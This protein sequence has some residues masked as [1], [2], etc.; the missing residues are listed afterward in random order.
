[1]GLVENAKINGKSYER[2]TE[3]FIKI[4]QCCILLFKFILKTHNA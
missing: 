1:M 4:L 3:K 2:K